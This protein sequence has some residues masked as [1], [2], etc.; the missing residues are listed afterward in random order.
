MAYF[1]TFIFFS[2]IVFAIYYKYDA[3][4]ASLKKQVILLSKQNRSLKSKMNIHM[5]RIKNFEMKRIKLISPKG[6]ITKETSLRISPISKSMPLNTLTE[7][8]LVEIITCVKISDITWYQLDIATTNNINSIGWVNENFLSLV[9][10][11]FVD[12]DKNKQSENK[13]I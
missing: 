12:F 2:V 7:N 9:D 8:Q 6:I 5:E 11:T 3:T 13:A 1:L 4:V 10:E